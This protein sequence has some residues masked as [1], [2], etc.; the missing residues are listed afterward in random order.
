MASPLL[1]FC[2][3]DE[4][5]DLFMKLFTMK[6]LTHLGI[7]LLAFVISMTIFACS[8][9]GSGMSTNNASSVSIKNF[10]FSNTSLGVTAGTTVTWT[11]N[12][13]TAHTVTADDGSFDSGNI[14]PG[15]SFTHTFSNM[16]TVNYHCTIH[17][18]MK[19]AVIVK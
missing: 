9:S 2:C 15:Q 4:R 1:A 6:K 14:A 17:P 19:A 11:N 10:A 12:D 16:G 18:M 13:A 8:K 3:I 5:R 7:V